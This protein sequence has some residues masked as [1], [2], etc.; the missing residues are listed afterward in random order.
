VLKLEVAPV[1]ITEMTI[2]HISHIRS[3]HSLKCPAYDTSYDQKR[4]LKMNFTKNHLK[5]VSGQHLE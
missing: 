2:Q 5:P 3:W 1:Q 4:T